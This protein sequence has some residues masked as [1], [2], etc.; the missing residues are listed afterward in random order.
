M[1]KK[2]K[3]SEISIE[4]GKGR[5]LYRIQALKDFSNVKAGEYGGFVEF[6]ENL[7]QEGNCWLYNNATAY[8]GAHVC[9]DATVCDMSIVS[10]ESRVY[11]SACI[12]GR[13]H[14]HGKSEVYENASLNGT[15]TVYGE[16]KIHG[17][18][19]I[20]GSQIFN[21]NADVSSPLHFLSVSPLTVF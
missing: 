4:I 3:L 20:I 10:E 13:C 11:G 21:A 2:F 19:N 7:S 9:E 6:E 1:D 5:K 16:A 18:V 15:V 17:D 14:I 12:V 8:G